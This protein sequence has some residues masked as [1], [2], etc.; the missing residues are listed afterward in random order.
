MG[1][2]KFWVNDFKKTEAVM[3][4]SL[5]KRAIAERWARGLWQ[6]TQ[7]FGRA[8]TESEV[9]DILKARNAAEEAAQVLTPGSELAALWAKFVAHEKYL[10]EKYA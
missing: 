3:W 8:P 5:G 6:F 1:A 10:A 7:R 4:S 2:E 9:Y